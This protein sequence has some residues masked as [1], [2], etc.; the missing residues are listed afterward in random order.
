MKITI[1]IQIQ[2][3]MI[4]NYFDKEVKLFIKISN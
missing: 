3:K 2:F 1:W 4:M